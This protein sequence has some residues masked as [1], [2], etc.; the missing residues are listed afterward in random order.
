M[1]ITTRRAW[2]RAWNLIGPL[3]PIGLAV[4]L[5]AG[6]ALAVYGDPS[7]PEIPNDALTPGAVVSTDQREVCAVGGT[8]TYSREHRRTPAA[9]KAWVF[10][11]Y[12][13]EPPRGVERDNWE[14]DQR[15][16]LYLGGTDEAANL[17]P[18]NAASFHRKDALEAHVCREVCL[19][20]VPLPEAQGW[21]LGDWRDAYKREIGK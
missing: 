8:E 3:L 10:R 12:G 9:L 2:R 15:I 6:T 20:A 1:K 16:P 18:Q 4:G 17:W 11:E 19:G 21:F 13:M 14:V 7:Y 5:L